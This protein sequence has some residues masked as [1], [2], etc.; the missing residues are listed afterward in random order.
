MTGQL[1]LERVDGLV[2]ALLGQFPGLAEDF[3]R[4]PDHQLELDRLLGIV[5]HQERRVVSYQAKDSSHSLVIG[6]GKMRP[7]AF[8]KFLL[9][10]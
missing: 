2:A 3:T 5:T 4:R 6:I 10:D 8:Y 7:A 1:P 9:T